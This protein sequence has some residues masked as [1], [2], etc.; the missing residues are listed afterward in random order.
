[1]I[2]KSM[3]IVL[4]A[5]EPKPE[6]ERE[7]QDRTLTF[8]YTDKRWKAEGGLYPGEIKLASLMDIAK[9]NWGGGLK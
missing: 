7:L 2:I 4:G 1:M 6:G 3:I 9:N 8:D 5:K